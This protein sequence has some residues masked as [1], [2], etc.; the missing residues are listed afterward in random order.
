MGWTLTGRSTSSVL[1]ALLFNIHLSNLF[2]LTEFNDVYNFADDT[3]F[4]A[5]DSDLKHLMERLKHNAKLAIE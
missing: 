1:G 5:C 3:T 2:Y 4:F